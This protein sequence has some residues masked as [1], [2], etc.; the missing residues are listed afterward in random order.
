M[1]YIVL[2]ITHDLFVKKG[3]SFKSSA[4]DTDNVNIQKENEYWCETDYY[5]KI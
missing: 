3:E 4:T 5:F 2:T 1:N